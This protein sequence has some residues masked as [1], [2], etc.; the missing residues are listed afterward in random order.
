MVFGIVRPAPYIE[1]ISKDVCTPQQ[2]EILKRREARTDLHDPKRMERRRKQLLLKLLKKKDEAAA[3]ESELQPWLGWVDRMQESWRKF[4][5]LLNESPE[6]NKKN[7][8]KPKSKKT[9]LT[10]RIKTTKQKF[11]HKV[12]PFK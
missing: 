6:S 3:D 10:S 8:K 9:K 11:K 1:V 12:V 7:K 4:E 5:Q 2:E